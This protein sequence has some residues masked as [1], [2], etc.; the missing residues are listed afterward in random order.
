MS[1]NFKSN[2]KNP[3]DKLMLK[4]IYNP[5]YNLLNENYLSPLHI[6]NNFNVTTE[7]LSFY[8]NE[9]NKKS[10]KKKEMVK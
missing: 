10:N 2:L 4:T 6:K 7:H 9:S 8:A 5:R 3:P 1:R